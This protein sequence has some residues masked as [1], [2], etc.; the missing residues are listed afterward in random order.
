MDCDSICT[1]PFCPYINKAKL[2]KSE[3]DQKLKHLNVDTV[4]I[5]GRLVTHECE[6]PHL[7]NVKA[8]KELGYNTFVVRDATGGTEED[9]NAM[10][11][12]GIQVVDTS[13]LLIDK[14][15]CPDDDWLQCPLSGDCFEKEKLCN[16]YADCIGEEIDE[17]PKEVIEN[18]CDEFIL[19]GVETLSALWYHKYMGT[20]EKVECS[21][22][23]KYKNCC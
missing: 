20:Y 7:D 12:I 14:F 23:T 3:M 19:S 6:Y 8:A 5:A 22:Y 9:F 1:M 21:R 10:I 11:N 4:F 2:F 17:N 13:T 16:G 18:C 15:K